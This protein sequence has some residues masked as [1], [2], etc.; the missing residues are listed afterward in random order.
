[1]SRCDISFPVL[2][3]PVVLASL[4]KRAVMPR[5]SKIVSRSCAQA[6]QV[7][8]RGFTSMRSCSRNR[9][10]ITHVQQWCDKLWFQREQ[11]REKSTIYPSSKSA[12]ALPDSKNA[13]VRTSAS[14]IL[15]PVQAPKI[16]CASCRHWIW[17]S[18]SPSHMLNRFAALRS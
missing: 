12:A 13:D 9:H 1:M 8:E 3:T 2:I 10:T 5:S 16:S 4:G 7:W 18:I 14:F 11:Q 17:T 6:L 15:A